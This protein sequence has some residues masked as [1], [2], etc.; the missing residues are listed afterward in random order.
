[1]SVYI[2]N[3]GGKKFRHLCLAEP[4]HAVARHQSDVALAICRVVYDY[5]IGHALNMLWADEAGF[6]GLV[7]YVAEDAEDAAYV[8]EVDG[9]RLVDEAAVGVALLV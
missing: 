4:Y 1:M 8:G 7:D 5:F 2:W 6:A 3:R 9:E